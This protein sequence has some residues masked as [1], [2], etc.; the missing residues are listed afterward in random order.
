MS[1]YASSQGSSEISVTFAVKPEDE[2]RGVHAMRCHYKI[3]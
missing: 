2:T 1:I 3:L